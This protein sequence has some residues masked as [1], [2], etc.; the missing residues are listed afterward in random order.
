MNKYLIKILNE[1]KIKSLNE[2]EFL[3]SVNEV[4][5]S[6]TP[7]LEQNKDYITYNILKRII[8]P[9]RTI[10][11]QIPWIDDNNNIC[12]NTGY[13]V[14]F[15][16]AI[17]PYKGGLRFHPSVNLSII[18]FLGFEQIFKNSLTG[19]SL[20]GAKG[21]SDFD[22]KHKSNFEIMRFCQNFMRELYKYIGSDTDIPAG[23]IGVGEKEIGYMYGQ[24]KK[25]K[26]EHTGTLTGKNI[27]WSGSLMRPEATGYGA[28]YFMIEMLK[29]RNISLQNKKIMI[30]GCGNVAQYTA[31]KAIQMGGKV[32]SMS[33][34]QGTIIDNDGINEEKLYFI[35]N[36]KNIKR[37]T[38][39]K[40]TEQFK[41]SKYFYGQKPWKL[42]KTDLAFPSA[43]QN[44]ITESD[45]IKLIE[46]GCIGISE[47]ANMPSTPDAIKIFNLK[48]ILFGPSKAA[49]SG[50]V[51]VSGLEMAQNSQKLSWSFD[52]IDKKL[53]NI[54]INIHKKIIEA[55]EIYGTK[56]YVDG[57]NIIGFKKV[58]DTMIN[59]GV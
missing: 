37:D 21:G 51:A 50:G 39:K 27:N 48:N 45:A 23:D 33:D 59:M 52:E 15:N 32:I 1:I 2:K 41:H 7:L 19:L 55:T 22:P 24:Y 40:Y 54:M 10:I 9:D 14:Q 28:V 18:K 31:E 16:N 35:K 34:S 20:G 49:N 6:L 46:N 57:A 43:T 8:Y 30:S 3:Q 58:A 17:G 4:F 42:T 56:N 44:E 26:N 47:G 12:V 38:I 25:I 11:F 53:Q 13:R 5:L 36:L 29:T